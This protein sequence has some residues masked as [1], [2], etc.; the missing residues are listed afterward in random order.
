MKTVLMTGLTGTLGPK[1]AA[2]FTLR[3]WRVLEWNHHIV[4][5][6]DEQQSTQFWREHT[7]DAVCHMAMG[8][9]NWAAWLATRCKEQG[10]PFLFVSTAMVFDSEID[11]PYGIFQERN[12]RE[13]YGQYKIQCEDA[14]WN[15]NPDAM[16][17]RI[18]W[19]I[20]DETTG[21]NMLAHLEQQHLEQGVINASEAWFPATS[22]MD[23]TAIAFLQLIERNEPGLYHLDSNA[24]NRWSFYKLVCALSEHYDKGWH[25]VSNEDYKHDQR[26]VD[27]RIALPQLSHRFD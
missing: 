4:S 9:E 21:N 1:V 10:I 19:Q 18:G 27:E 8:D 23:D 22:H 7:I 20:H 16:I 3:G 12:A 15:V 5:P 6:Q 26:L 2:Q 11:G 25:V 24:K 13:A 14:I 17:A